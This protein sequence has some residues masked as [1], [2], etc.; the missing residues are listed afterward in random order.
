MYVREI[1]LVDISCL[2]IGQRTAVVWCDEKDYYSQ[3]RKDQYYRE[4]PS[5]VES[6]T[7][8]DTLH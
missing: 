2:L 6:L 8:G 4:L 3:T 1:G 7:S 5:F